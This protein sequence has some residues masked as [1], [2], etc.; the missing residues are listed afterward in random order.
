[1]KRNDHNVVV[2]VNAEDLE[3]VLQISTPGTYLTTRRQDEE[4]L[5]LYVA[6]DQLRSDLAVHFI[7]GSGI[8]SL[9]IHDCPS[10]HNHITQVT[11]YRRSGNFDNKQYMIVHSNTLLFGAQDEA[12]ETKDWFFMSGYYT[13]DSSRN[14][15]FIPT[16]IRIKAE[17]GDGLVKLNHQDI[18]D[19][20]K[21]LLF[22]GSLIEAQIRGERPE[23]VIG[24]SKGACSLPSPTPSL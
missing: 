6:L 16:D 12:R 22:I 1:M 19:V 18:S 9:T 13:N 20:R 2:M 10:P 23:T 15:H 5:P 11:T 24:Q 3:Q 14:K 21:G 8:D 4:T 7:E 17:D